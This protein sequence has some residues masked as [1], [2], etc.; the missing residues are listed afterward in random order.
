[1]TETQTTP[2]V[3]PPQGMNRFSLKYHPQ[4]KVKR[5]FYLASITDM[6]VAQ[7]RHGSYPMVTFQLTAAGS[8]QSKYLWRVSLT[9]D[10]IHKLTQVHR[11]IGLPTPSLSALKASGELD[12]D[13][14]L[15]SNMLI[16]LAPDQYQG[17]WRSIIAEIRPLSQAKMIAG[18]IADEEP[19]L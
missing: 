4:P 6:G 1:M 8:D 17:K 7:S 13:Q 9:K 5:G 18:I 11:A 16:H 15:G 12:P 19:H 2:T 3:M 14:Y 10:D